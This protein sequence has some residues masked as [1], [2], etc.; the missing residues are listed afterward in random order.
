M[1]EKAG[2]K[3]LRLEDAF[4]GIKFGYYLGSYS[5]ILLQLELPISTLLLNVDVDQ[6]CL[7]KEIALLF[8]F[9]MMG[10]ESKESWLEQ[11]RITKN[12]T[13]INPLQIVVGKPLEK[14]QPLIIIP[15]ELQ[16]TTESINYYD[17]SLGNTSSSETKGIAVCIEDLQCDLSKSIVQD[18]S[19]TVERPD[20]MHLLQLKG[21]KFFHLELIHGVHFSTTS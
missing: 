21:D 3:G 11:V 20:V 8:T 14:T 19:K 7:D 6:S 2:V 9:T 12:I 15:V 16:N 17:A 5:K 4:S 1:E 10:E 18:V 13:V